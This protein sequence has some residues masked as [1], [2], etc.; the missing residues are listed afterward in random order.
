MSG[1]EMSS[2]GSRSTGL[3]GKKSMPVG[4]LQ[5]SS[6]LQTGNQQMK[7]SYYI[8]SPIMRL[9]LSVNEK[10]KLCARQVDDIRTELGDESLWW[11][12]FPVFNN[13]GV[14]LRK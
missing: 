5:T 11:F 4:T 2:L 14:T 7:H 6:S 3:T 12:D 8:W 13:G 1:I 10:G 9:A